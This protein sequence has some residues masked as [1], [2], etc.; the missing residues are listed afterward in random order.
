M[1]AVIP[2]LVVKPEMKKKTRKV[3]K[4]MKGKTWVKGFYKT[5]KKTPKRQ[6]PY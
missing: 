5:T 4:K 2:D 6:K 1:E 3:V